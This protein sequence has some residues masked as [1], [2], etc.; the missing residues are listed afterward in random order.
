MAPKGFFMRVVQSFNPNAYSDLAEEKLRSS[1]RHFFLQFI[2][3]FVI[4]ALLFVPAYFVHAD[5]LKTT[6]ASFTTAEL[7]GSFESAEPVVLID[8]PRVVFDANA[9]SAKGAQIVLGSQEV[10]YKKYYWFGSTSAAY[11]DLRNLGALDARVVVFLALFIWPSLVFWS[12]MYILVKMFFF[13]L[14]FSFLAWILVGAFKQSITYK[15]S[16]KV[17]LYAAIPAL[18]FE[19]LLFGFWRNAWVT[20]AIYLLFFII[21]IA[22]LSERKKRK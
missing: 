22:L 19:M 10:F 20:L 12:G 14:L 17:A 7:D 6:F 11:S 5:T 2:I 16:L 18:V 3:L 21:G 1:L 15:R 9:T 4:M 13:I 8:S